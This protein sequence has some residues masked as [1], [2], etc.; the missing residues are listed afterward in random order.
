MRM[1]TP[2]RLEVYVFCANTENKYKKN[3]TE[4]MKRESESLNFIAF[5]IAFA[6]LGACTVLATSSAR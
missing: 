3:I 6:I 4:T 5:L 2:I 1:C